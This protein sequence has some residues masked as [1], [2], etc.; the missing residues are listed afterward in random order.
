MTLTAA[1]KIEL[2]EAALADSKYRT[3]QKQLRELRDAQQITLQRYLSDSHESLKEEAQRIILELKP[4]AE[5]Q[6][7]T[8]EQKTDEVLV[9]LPAGTIANNSDFDNRTSNT[10]TPQDADA[11]TKSELPETLK[12]GYTKLTDQQ[13]NYLNNLDPMEIYR[14]MTQENAVRLAPG[15]YDKWRDVQEILGVPT[16]SR[17]IARQKYGYSSVV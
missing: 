10:E 16:L 4:I 3:L 5:T 14:N 2:I 11:T 6:N 8:V 9:S 12:S 17:H 15:T 1:A 13:T 7:A